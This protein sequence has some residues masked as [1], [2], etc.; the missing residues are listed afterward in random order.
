MCLG[1]FRKKHNSD[2]SLSIGTRV[3]V[4]ERT[5]AKDSCYHD[6]LVT[7]TCLPVF[8]TIL[9]TTASKMQKSH[10]HPAHDHQ[11]ATLFNQLIK[12]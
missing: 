5:K 11:H 4:N 3:S 10:T 8:M 7:N 9:K 6:F 2:F 12:R 1:F